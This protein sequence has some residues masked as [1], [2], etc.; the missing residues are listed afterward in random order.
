V[1]A[2]DEEGTVGLGDGRRL[3]YA[4]YGPPEGDPLL[5]FHG[6][7]GSRYARVPDRSG[8]VDRGV[9][10]LTL[11]RP[12]F[13]LSTHDPGRELLDWPGDVE[14]AAD[15]LGLG[16]FAALGHSGGA[17]YALACAARI[18]DR[19]TAVGVTGGLGPLSAPG[20]TDGMTIANRIGFR[21]ARVPLVLRPFLWYR[22]RA[23]RSDPAG[24]VDA[25]ADEAAA[26]DARVL[27]DPAVRAV[28]RQNFPAAVAQGPKAP[29]TETRLHVRDWGFDL[30]EIPLALHVWHGEEDVFTPVAMAEHVAQTVPSA[31]LHRSPD[32]G[33]L[34]HFERWDEQLATLLED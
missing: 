21:L 2:P 22:I 30:G 16:R 24:F 3:G 26:P 33:H 34:L 9:R 28:L 18:P 11:E 10:Q 8:L 4:A 1:P 7:P 19:L 20:A 15:A 5:F 29:L 6:T 32:A 27:E 25:W 23:I 17:P 13:G 12:G 31:T 14:A